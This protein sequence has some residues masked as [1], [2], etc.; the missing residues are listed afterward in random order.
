MLDDSFENPLGTMAAS[1]CRVWR[2]PASHRYLPRIVYRC[3]NHSRHQNADKNSFIVTPDLEAGQTNLPVLR[4]AHH[5]P[6]VSSHPQT[7][8]R[9]PKE[10]KPPPV[11]HL[12]SLPCQTRHRSPR[13]SEWTKPAEQSRVVMISSTPTICL[14]L[15]RYGSMPTARSTL[16]RVTL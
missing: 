5:R 16:S 7:P 4:R 14:S 9:R 13:P 1:M 8:C 10:A 6:L 11:S 12:K 15:C 3:C 2:S